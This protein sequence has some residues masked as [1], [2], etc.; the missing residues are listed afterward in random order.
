MADIST[1]RVSDNALLKIFLDKTLYK[2][3]EL[4]LTDNA[5]VSIVIDAN[6]F[7][8]GVNDTETN[9]FIS[10][11]RED[12]SVGIRISSITFSDTGIHP[13]C[14]Y[15]YSRSSTSFIDTYTTPVKAV[16]NNALQLGAHLSQLL[17]P[18]SN[19][20]QASQSESNYQFASAHHEVLSRLEQLASEFVEKQIKQASRLEEE[21]QE[22]IDQR[23]AEFAEKVNSQNE[24]YTKKLN[25]LDE[26]YQKRQQELD[27]R[28]KQIEDADNTTTRR[29]TTSRTLEEAQEKAK[30]FN[31]SRGVTIR[32]LAAVALGLILIFMGIYNTITA[33]NELN[34]IQST[35]KSY[36]FSIINAENSAA[37][38][39]D[40]D[41][42]TKQH[43][44]FL[45]LRIVLGSALTISSIIYLIRWFNSWADRIAQQE[46]DNQLFIRDLNRAQLA[47]EMSLEWNEKKD[48]D[49]PLRLLESI[50]EGLFEP[51][52]KTS[53]ELLHPAEQ[54]AAALI[55]GSDKITLPFSGGTIETNGKSIRKAKSIQTTSIENND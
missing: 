43:M 41:E 52:N 50:T 19:I 53:K 26:A 13:Q 37:P 15:K 11:M 55:R 38:K 10:S 27:E 28:Q 12:S 25:T 9:D 6:V 24:S 47:V 48:G 35:F 32:G 2:R 3:A 16:S 7:K 29:R 20:F 8:I 49:I 18:D 36:Q 17:I 34:D 30:K 5:S 44:Y 46:L 51:Q 33:S 4:G 42:I 22:F 1:P 45:Y 40:T 31:F 23:S 54:I 39:P 21:K 14:L